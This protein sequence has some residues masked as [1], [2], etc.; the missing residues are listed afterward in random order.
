MHFECYGITKKFS[1]ADRMN[2]F[3]LKNKV[4]KKDLQVRQKL[5][6]GNLA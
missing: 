5:A 4:M 6:I 3:S 1:Q 2:T